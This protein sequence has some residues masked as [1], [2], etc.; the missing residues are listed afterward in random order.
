MKLSCITSIV[1]LLGLGSL[2]T[3]DIFRVD[4]EGQGDY[5]TINEAV[6]D[7]PDGSTIVIASG[8]YREAIYFNNRDLTLQG[9]GEVSIT[10]CSQNDPRCEATRSQILYIAWGSNIHLNNITVTG[11]LRDHMKGIWIEE[12]GEVTITDCRIYRND[13][14]G[15][16]ITGRCGPVEIVNTVISENQGA[17]LTIGDTTV[18]TTTVSG[19]SI[20]QN[21]HMQLLERSHQ[22]FSSGIRAYGNSDTE[23]GAT[24][25][26]NDTVIRDNAAGYLGA[27]MFI[28]AGMDLVTI[29]QCQFINNQ[30]IGAGGAG[31]ALS[32]TSEADYRGRWSENPVSVR[33]KV[34]NTEFSGNYSSYGGAV[35]I[36]YFG[37]SGLVDNT[38]K[39]T[40]CAFENNV[41]YAYG[42]AVVMMGLAESNISFID[43]A[44]KRNTGRIGG[45]FFIQNSG[46]NLNVLIDKSELRSNLVTLSNPR[47]GASIRN[48]DPFQV[49]V[50]NTTICDGYAPIV[51]GWND[52]NNVYEEGC[53]FQSCCF[54]GQCVDKSEMECL[55]SGGTWHVNMSCDEVVCDPIEGACCLGSW[56][57]TMTESECDQ[58]NGVYQGNGSKCEPGY[59]CE[60]RNPAD[61]DLNGKVNV[62]DLMKFFDYWGK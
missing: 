8:L 7:V 19:C 40:A 14:Y 23:P 36:G 51:G 26:V 31:A 56:C 42:G 16:M 48:M 34:D 52:D 25:H 46:S 15:I 17:G 60:P 29:N 24:L 28:G 33:V 41:A 3:A 6:D 32:I 27:G 49:H 47:E 45:A 10:G 54:R 30:G 57:A 21:S 4:P 44:F 9:E 37:P 12:S 53:T 22:R 1:A 39:F 35:F 50:R 18:G 61:F 43:C 62:D 5:L 20:Y 55:E 13:F 58:H 38:V 2:A 11:E 59:T